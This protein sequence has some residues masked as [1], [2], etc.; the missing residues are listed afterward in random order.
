MAANPHAMATSTKDTEMAGPAPSR[1]LSVDALPPF[2]NMSNTVALNID[3]AKKC[4]P[5]AAVPVTVKMPDPMTAPTPSAIK[6]QTPSDF[7][8]RRSGSSEAAIRASMLLVRRSWFTP[9]RAA[10]VRKRSPLTLP[11]ALRHLQHFLLQGAASHSGCPLRLGSRFLAGGA[12]Y[13]LA[14]CS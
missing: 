12:L 14:L 4:S 6:L 2:S 1:P 13:F 11:L 3:L 9:Y 8:S 5:A 7:F 10:P